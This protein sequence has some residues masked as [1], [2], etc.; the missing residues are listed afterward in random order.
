MNRRLVFWLARIGAGDPRALAQLDRLNAAAGG[1]AGAAVGAALA[2]IAAPAAT[3][4][5]T[6]AGMGWR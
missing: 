6:L 4:L 3:T 2:M 5:L 1:M